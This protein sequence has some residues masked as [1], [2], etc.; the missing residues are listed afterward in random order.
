[1]RRSHLC[2]VAAFAI[3]RTALQRRIVE[4]LLTGPEACDGLWCNLLLVHGKEKV[5]ASAQLAQLRNVA[6]LK[7]AAQRPFGGELEEFL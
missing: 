2:V 7:H 5:L 3:R 1:M 4:L 6:M